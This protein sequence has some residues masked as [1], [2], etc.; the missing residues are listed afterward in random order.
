MNRIGPGVEGED[1]VAVVIERRPNRT[2]P[3]EDVL[4]V[5]CPICGG[6]HMHGGKRGHIGSHGHRVSHCLSG[7]YVVVDKVPL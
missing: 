7:G 5:K 4:Y 2:R 3:T 6:T 1:L